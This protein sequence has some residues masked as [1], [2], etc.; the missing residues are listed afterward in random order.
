VS[1]AGAGGISG[2]AGGGVGGIS[3]ASGN[4]G[5]GGAVP[6]VATACAYECVDD[7]DC[8]VGI[9]VSHV[10]DPTLKRC[11]RANEFCDTNAD[12]IPLV[13][14][15]SFAC[16]STNDCFDP[17]EVCVEGRGTGYCVAPASGEC[18]FPGHE[19]ITVK[20]LGSTD[21]VVVCGATNGRCNAHNKCFEGCTADSDCV[22]QKNGTTC[23][24]TTG[25]CECASDNDCKLSTAKFCNMQTHRCECR[26]D[27]ECPGDGYGACIAGE[28][29]C[30]GPSVCKAPFANVTPRC[31]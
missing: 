5:A 28:C 23:N 21:T 18:L 30:S 9:D 6:S 19:K 1:G 7:A 4:A 31:E 14:S 22:A 2:A 16:K 27:N 11:A 24:V 15:W 12:C 26:A 20:K 8:K 25:L 17:S 10:C 13:S 29:S 3:G